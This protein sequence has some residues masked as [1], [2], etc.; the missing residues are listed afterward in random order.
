M[1]DCPADGYE[2]D[3]ADLTSLLQRGVYI[4]IPDTI[5]VSGFICRLFQ[6]TPDVLR[7]DVRTIMLNNQIVDKPEDIEL[8]RG[9]TL[10]LSGAMPGLVGAMFRSDSPFKAMRE[11]VTAK[12]RA[13]RRRDGNSMVRLKLLNTILTKYRDRILQYGYSDQV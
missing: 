2:L 10:V 7:E 8:K 12:R 6:I 4:K 13:E 3:N 5:T 9:D 1:N 11:T